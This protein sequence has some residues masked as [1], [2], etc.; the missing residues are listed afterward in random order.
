MP[1]I[2]TRSSARRIEG[3]LSSSRM[4]EF[5]ERWLNG[6]GGRFSPP[7]HNSRS[8]SKYSSAFCVC[9]ESAAVQS[10]TALLTTAAYAPCALDSFSFNFFIFSH[11]G[12]YWRKLRWFQHGNEIESERFLLLQFDIWSIRPHR[13]LPIGSSQ[14]RPLRS[15]NNCES[16]PWMIRISLNTKFTWPACRLL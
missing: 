8:F 9:G 1:L 12:L 13:S 5:G 14:S 7:C 2:A 10:L 6:T 11:T 15:R 16:L 4:L 3:D